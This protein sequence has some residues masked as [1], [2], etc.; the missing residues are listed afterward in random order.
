MY[1]DALTYLPDDILV[2]VDRAA[3]SVS[4][5]TRVPFLHPEVVS[6]ASTVPDEHRRQGADGKVLLRSLLDRYVPRQLV[7][8]PKMGF[9]VPVGSWLRG[10]LRP[11][12]E[13]LLSHTSLEQEGNLAPGPIRDAWARHLSG[14]YDLKYPLWNV[15]MYR[16]WQ[17]SQ[18]DTPHGG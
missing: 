10:P 8:R 3:M 16:E 11:W 6:F 7:D 17:R 5:E 13:D 9:G 2:K 1:A 15:L 12:A 14:R 18:S 4:L